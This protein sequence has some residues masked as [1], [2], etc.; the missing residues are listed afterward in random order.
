MKLPEIDTILLFERFSMP[1]YKQNSYE[2]IQFPD[3]ELPVI[4]HCDTL[5]R[6]DDFI[7]HWQDSPELL[8]FIEGE[9]EVVSDIQREVC[10]T[11]EIAFINCGQLHTVRP[12][13][14][15]CRYYCL[16]AEREFLEQQ[17]VP[18]G[19]VPARLRLSGPVF[20]ELFEQIIGE[21]L[22]REAYY[23]PAVKACVLSLTAQILRHYPEQRELTT[24]AQ[25]KRIAMVKAAVRYIQEHFA[26]ELDIDK[27]SA[28]AGFS[29]Y[30][31]CRG[32]KEVTGRTP[33]EYLNFVRCSCA[34]RLILSGRCNV[35]EA[36]ERCG[37][38]N[39]SYFSRT[40]RRYMGVLPSQEK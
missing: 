33:V 38:A 8:Y 11:G 32:F 34:R 4:F 26:E 29:K 2:N 19:T 17:G 15:V 23:R 6:E 25:D 40:Y 28:A 16:I 37:F 27:I 35:S 36:A 20:S 10:R 5:R 39:L 22:S 12:L 1:I 30:H 13:T 31:F 24:P 18:A 14:P 3:P 9:A 7:M 21:M